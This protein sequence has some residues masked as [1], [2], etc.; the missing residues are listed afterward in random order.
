MRPV[1]LLSDFGLDD[2]Y[3]G[4]MHAVLAREA[5]GLERLDLG[6]QVPPGDVW[7]A[8]YLLRAAWP[9]LPADC[10]AL[11]VVDPGVGTSRRAV[12][13][14]VGERCLVAPDNGLV[15]ALAPASQAVLLDPV[16]M[17]LQPPSAT[18][19]GRD[20]FAPAAARIARGDALATLGQ[21]LDPAGLVPCPLPRPVA[22]TIGWVVSVLWVDRFENV[23]TNL[24]VA[25]MGE[26]VAVRLEAGRRLRRVQAYGE[27]ADG[28][29]VALEGSSGL[30]ELA[31]N[32]GSAAEQ[33]GLRR[34]ERIHLTR[35]RG[36]H[37][38]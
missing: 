33:L 12:A 37:E 28:E 23:V 29:V 21:A 32:R 5:P 4:V 6:H 10:V 31:V 19:H 26:A 3:A 14:A 30:L 24:P 17:G 20:L 8:C 13:V 25:D 34:G 2:H 18:F 35:S 36:G 38:G 9:H 1:A 15:A 22:T 27:G 7:A 11:A 16:R